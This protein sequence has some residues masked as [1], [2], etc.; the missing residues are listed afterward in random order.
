MRYHVRSPSSLPAS[1]HAALSVVF[2]M[3][4]G[5][6]PALRLA[7]PRPPRRRPTARHPTNSIR[8]LAILVAAPARTLAVVLFG[9]QSPALACVQRVHVASLQQRKDLGCPAFAGAPVLSGMRVVD[10]GAAHA[11]AKPRLPRSAPRTA[12]CTQQVNSDQLDTQHV[13]DKPAAPLHRSPFSRFAT[14]PPPIRRR[15]DS[16]LILNRI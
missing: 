11:G 15:S 13:T 3:R 7:A 5:A 14:T 9:L 2:R 1:S 10:I 8:P 16:H 4:G 6:P 12:C